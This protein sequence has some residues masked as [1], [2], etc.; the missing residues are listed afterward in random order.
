MRSTRWASPGAIATFL[1]VGMVAHVVVGVA[2]VNRAQAET[3]ASDLEVRAVN[4]ADGLI[5]CQYNT[6]QGIFPT[7]DLWQSGNT[8][9]TLAA[10]SLALR[11]H[12]RDRYGD[13]FA[14]TFAR[15][16]AVLDKCF[17]DHQWWLN[18]WIRIYEVTGHRTYLDRAAIIHDYVVAHGWETDTCGGGVLW[19]PAPTNPYKNAIT[20]ELFI[21][22]SARL[23]P[24][25]ALVNR[26]STYYLDWAL[27]AWRW[28]VQSG[29]I[30][31]NHLVNDGLD[32]N[33]QNNNGTTWTYNQG[34][35]LDG[36]VY[37]DRFANSTG[38]TAVARAVAMA[39]S[40][41]L[42]SAAGA[43]TEPCGASCDGD[44]QI[45]KGVFAR[46]LG[47]MLDALPLDDGSDN[48]AFRATMQLFLQR[49]VNLLLD[50][51]SCSNS[52]DN[53]FAPYG[54]A[55]D[56]PCTVATMATSSA[57]LDLL[58]ALLANGIEPDAAGRV[59]WPALGLGICV[60]ASG[61]TMPSC[62]ID[63]VT[64]ADCGQAAAADP[65]AVAYEYHTS[66]AGK[67]T[68]VVRTKGTANSCPHGWSFKQGSASSVSRGD[69]SP[70]AI[71][72]LRPA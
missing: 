70:L 6:S 61:A 9:D 19:C 29:M 72:A 33:C 20:T 2:G 28:F 42:A 65:L 57:A 56:G 37:I 67:T 16:A 7:E 5:Q 40:T 41:N 46:R 30:D 58:T 8:L 36:A 26:S 21:T 12:S 10:L 4:L 51:A 60:D 68:C 69:G 45:F 50:R 48:E 66:C 62:S 63:N 49:N 71:C 43:L 1:C 3:G 39:A 53:G 55:W 13:I 34:C 27:N 17:D 47:Y 54:L 25:A 31:A 38:A 59:T 14:N 11:N 23:Q 22:A 24:Y 32:G 64:E 18:A 15:T 35:F 52:S 44:Q